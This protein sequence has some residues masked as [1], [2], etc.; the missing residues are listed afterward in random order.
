MTNQKLKEVFLQEIMVYRPILMRALAKILGEMEAKSVFRRLAAME[1]SGAFVKDPEAMRR[2]GAFF[3]G[4]EED[5]GFYVLSMHKKDVQIQVRDD[6]QIEPPKLTLETRPVF[7]YWDEAIKHCASRLSAYE[8]PKYFAP[9]LH[10]FCHF[11]CYCL[12]ARPMMAATSLLTS[13]LGQ[14]GVRLES[15]QGLNTIQDKERG[16]SLW[17]LAASLVQL[18]GTNEA[19]A[20]WWEIRLLRGME[21]E[22]G[23]YLK[24]KVENNPYARQMLDLETNK[25]LEYIRNW[26]QK[27]YYHEQF[28]RDFVGSFQNVQ[29][30]RWEFLSADYADLRRFRGKKGSTNCTNCT[31]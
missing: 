27:R 4:E 15:L 6:G 28:T 2:L 10:E 16:S 18:T 7:L 19:M 12:Q 3:V 5:L 13:A 21:F 14:R 8:L 24:S 20:I 26:G 11:L 22:P 31:K 17:K 1:A 23:D 30:D 29:V 25:V 9:W